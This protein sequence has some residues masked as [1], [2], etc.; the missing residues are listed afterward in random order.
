MS[1]SLQDIVDEALTQA[2]AQEQAYGGSLT[3]QWPWNIAKE[4]A[5]HLGRHGASVTEL[6]KSGSAVATS[7]QGASTVAAVKSQPTSTAATDKVLDNGL[8]GPA[9]DSVRADDLL[10]TVLVGFAGGAQFGVA[11]GGGG[12]GVATDV[13]DSSSRA[14]VK[15]GEFDLG[16]GGKI[17]AGLVV[18][19]MS[20]QPSA[21]NHSTCVWA[22]GASLGASV[23][24]EVI[25]RSKDLSLIGFALNLGGG[26]GAASTTGYGSI[27]TT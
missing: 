11:G 16:I 14:G 27:S 3:F 18:G 4:G 21:L 12:A 1:E 17:S 7:P 8:F 26:A 5:K 13:V 23:Y 2:D 20:E 9:I 10:R 6:V 25:M 15:Y 19:A 24:V 22:F